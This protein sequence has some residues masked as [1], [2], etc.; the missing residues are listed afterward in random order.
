M[1]TPVPPGPTPDQQGVV[2]PPIPAGYPQPGIPHQAPPPWGAQPGGWTPPPPQPGAWSPMLVPLAPNGAPLASF[3]QRL[4]AHLIDTLVYM[5]IYFVLLIP[6]M[7]IWISSIVSMS[8]D[9]NGQVPS[10]EVFTLMATMFGVMIAI[11][12]VLLLFTYLYYVEY[13]LRTNGRT[14][15]KKLMKLQVVPVDPTQPLTRGDLAKRWGIQYVAAAFVPFLSYLDGLWQLWDKPLQQC[16][17]DKV[18]K[19]VVVKVG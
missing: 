7:I 12:G 9:A 2:R 10:D 1:T 15:G 3:G 13:Q 14:L 16:L 18:A 4:G 17:H 19:T 11:V 5:A 6:V 8:P